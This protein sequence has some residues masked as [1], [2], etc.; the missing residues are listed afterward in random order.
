MKF[1]ENL[2]G[3]FGG[4]SDEF[5]IEGHPKTVC[6]YEEEP[7]VSDFG[8]GAKFLIRRATVMTSDL[9]IKLKGCHVIVNGN[10]FSVEDFEHKLGVT[11]LILI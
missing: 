11:V 1:R 8:T 5:I 6:I 3:F 9:P 7:G 4:W 10:Q 2:H